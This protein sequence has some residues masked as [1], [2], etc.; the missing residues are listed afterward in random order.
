[1]ARP[2]S[3]DRDHALDQAMHQ[4]WRL[5]YDGTSISDLTAE[6]GIAGPSIYAAFGSKGELFEEAVDHY[7]ADPRSVT[8][9]GLRGTSTE[10]LVRA[11]LER[12]AS[13]YAGDDHPRGCLVNSEPRLGARRAAN[14]AVTADR[15][16]EVGAD[17]GLDPEALA[18]YLQALLV[19]L[20]SYARDG[21]T[22][23]QLR[24]VVDVA[25]AALTEGR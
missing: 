19:G 1:M 5:G 25:L 15:L 12:A 20:S 8:A 16:R 21:A 13:E 4:F 2:R 17:E 6:L 11:M 9:A 14:R 23:A 7:E 10:E 24:A 22:E 3:F 18:A